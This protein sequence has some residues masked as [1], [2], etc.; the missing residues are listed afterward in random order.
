MTHRLIT[1][2]LACILFTVVYAAS[3]QP[4]PPAAVPAKAICLP[5]EAGGIGTQFTTVDHPDQQVI[6][7]TYLCNGQPMWVYGLYSWNPL[8]TRP[9][10]SGTLAAELKKLYVQMG[11][12]NQNS[13]PY[14]EMARRQLEA[15]QLTPTE[16]K[17]QQTRANRSMV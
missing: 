1:L 17:K 6:I 11:Y 15:Y 9:V 16:L 7:Y 3:A 10:K 8:R 12:M 13:A 5:Q 14:D 2:I 4:Q